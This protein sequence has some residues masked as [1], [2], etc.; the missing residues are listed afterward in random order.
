M[1]ALAEGAAYSVT[2]ALSCH[3]Q[4]L[5]ECTQCGSFSVSHMQDIYHPS[6]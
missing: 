2:A 4:G 6:G 3:V 1:R 5:L